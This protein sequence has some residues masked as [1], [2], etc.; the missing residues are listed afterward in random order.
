[1]DRQTTAGNP[2]H[3]VSFETRLKRVRVLIEGTTIAHS[4]QAGLMFETDHRPVYYSPPEN[5]PLDLLDRTDVRGMR[6]IGQSGAEDN[7]IRNRSPRSH[8]PKIARLCWDK[9]DD[10]FEEDEEV[11][12]FAGHLYFY[13]ARVDRIEV[14]P[15]ISG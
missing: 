9:V 2:D 3:R 11:F 13:S 12:G 8:E 1:M 5:V 10:W 14:E 7:A 6:P 4:I 15:L